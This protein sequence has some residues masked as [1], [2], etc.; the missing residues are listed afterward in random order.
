MILMNTIPMSLYIHIPWC[1]KKC[2]YCDF[3]SHVARQ[4]LPETQYLEALVTDFKEQLSYLQHRQIK[5]IFI[6]GG[7][8]SLMPANFYRQLLHEI[9][10]YLATGVEITLEANPG[11]IDRAHFEGYYNAGINRISL[12]IQSLQPQKLKYL[13]RM[14]SDN[15]AIQAI[16]LVKDCGFTNFNCDLMFGLPEQRIEDALADLQGIIDEQPSHLSWYQLTIE[17]N[18]HFYRRPPTLPASD[19]IF[20]MQQQG[21]QLLAHYGYHQYEISA[22]AQHNKQCLHNLNYWQFGDYIGIGAGAHGKITLSDQSILR[23]EHHKNPKIYMH[24]ANHVQQHLV[25]KEQ[26]LFEFM[27]NALRLYQP[28]AFELAYQ[29]CAIARNEL[30][31]ALQKSIDDELITY[32]ETTLQLTQRGKQFVDDILLELT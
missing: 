21:Q 4:E 6:G 11:V 31:H 27:L 7:T 3:N 13:G 19:Y 25:P 26:R 10:P 9:A 15:D 12:G 14:H 2:P 16:K 18:T 8:P 23:T 30:L 29:R 1:I 20:E 28:I 17:P 5:T 32:D 22:Y 24:T